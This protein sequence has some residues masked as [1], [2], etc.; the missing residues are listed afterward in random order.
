MKVNII[1]YV[2]IAF[3]L[4]GAISCSDFLDKEVDLTQ[5]AD[6]VFNDY[7]MTRGFQARLYT[8]LPDAFGA[9]AG[10]DNCSR[11]CMTDNAVCYWQ[12]GMHTILN[13]GYT[14]N[15]HGYA[16]G[17]WRNDYAAI[18]AANQ[19]L[20]NA[21]SGVIGNAEKAGDD[22]R[23]YDRWIAET[24][25]LR[26][27]FH[28][29]LIGWFG[30]IPI[31]GDDE[32]GTPII[33]EP[34]S[35]IPE[36]TPAA[37]ALKWVADECD[38]YK[39]DLPFRYS[40]EE[41]NWGRVNGAAAYALKARALVYRASPLN[42]PSN[43][44]EWWNEAVQACVDFFNKNNQQ[45]NPYRLHSIGDP[46]QNYYDC[47]TTNPVHNNEYILSRSVWDQY[48]IE[49]AF[50]PC[51]FSG[52][53]NST[54]RNNPTQNLVDAY[55]TINGL[56]IDQDPS[57][58]PQNPFVNRDPRLE[59]TIFH[60]GSV[61]GDALDNEQREV[62]VTFGEGIDYQA[63][64]GGTLTG[65]YT[66]K[67]V[68]NMSWQNPHTFPKACPIFRYGEMLL[69]AAE[70]LNE[71][72]RTSEAFAYVN[73]VRARVGMPEYSGMDQA[74]LRERIRNERRIE[75]CFEDHRF[76][77]ERRWK[78]F[79]GQTQSSETSL[80]RYK[81]VYNI[82]GVT[83]RPGTATVFT[84]GPAETYNVRVFNSP[85]NYYFPIPYTE[86]VRTGLPQTPGWEM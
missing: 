53:A 8:Y 37:E 64:H 68:S 30:D 78:L 5:Q 59:Q 35:T 9:I 2:S 36:R 58:D 13:D 67:Y 40:N 34:S 66:K 25:V 56:P 24:R 22:N 79:E 21:K 26:A 38:K 81:Q 20:L 49:L 48:T 12:N 45:A 3:L 73:Q 1:K 74:T 69:N 27:I 47:F 50:S 17:F 57:Y 4:T 55:E 28:F 32:N 11:D 31:V 52:T 85:K 84:Y 86:V 23:L 33:L 61:W 29:D 51:G 63:L 82:Y 41:E 54:G 10:G 16:A 15:S 14:A 44:T 60:H 65:Y 80:P 6:N 70:A 46:N 71:A 77:D 7:D 75:L 83:V 76:F 62:D 39:D 18:R 72:G 42:N 19:F 43:N